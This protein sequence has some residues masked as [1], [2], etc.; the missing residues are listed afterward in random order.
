MSHAITLVAAPIKELYSE[1]YD[2]HHITLKS[3]SGAL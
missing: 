2:Y 1:L 3:I